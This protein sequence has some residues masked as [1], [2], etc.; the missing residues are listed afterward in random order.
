VDRIVGKELLAN[1]KV[2]K[3]KGIRIENLFSGKA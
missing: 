2:L 1:K 3:E